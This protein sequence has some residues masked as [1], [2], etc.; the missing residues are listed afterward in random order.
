MAYEAKG[1]TLGRGTVTW[2]WG[3]QRRVRRPVRAREEGG[4]DLG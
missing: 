2:D 4:K 1:L 3:G